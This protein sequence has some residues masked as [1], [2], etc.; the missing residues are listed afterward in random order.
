MQSCAQFL[1]RY[2]NELT[3]HRLLICFSI[4]CIIAIFFYD[5]HFK[6]TTRSMA[7][8]KPPDH[9]LRHSNL[10]PNT[11]AANVTNKLMSASL[12]VAVISGPKNTERRFTIRRTWALNTANNT[13]VFFIIGVENLQYGIKKN[14]TTEKKKY[15][16]L[17]LL[18]HLE[19]K[20][21]DLTSKVLQTFHWVS[22]NIMFDYLLKVDDDTFVRLDELVKRLES[23]PAE[24]LYWG[25]FNERSPIVK[26]GR[27]A[28][29]KTYICDTYVTYALGGRY[30]LSNDLVK[31]IANNSDRFKKFTNEDV[32]VGTWLAPL[33]VNMVH[34]KNFRMSGDCQEDQVVLH[35]ASIDDMK[36][37]YDSLSVNGTLCGIREK[38][39][40]IENK[41]ATKPDSP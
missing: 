22:R 1:K 19:D 34:D 35:Y 8:T 5:N 12:V 7:E 27:W 11:T 18:P 37:F 20:Y 23:K 4:L 24:R 38:E 15:N 17:V 39:E 3:A 40:K 25:Y 36:H 33:E 30:I 29:K 13:K 28:E 21:D 2:Y 32:S 16:D 41:N 31:Y 26:K 6:T 10:F 14:L 9:R